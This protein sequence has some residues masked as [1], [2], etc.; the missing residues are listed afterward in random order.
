MFWEFADA[1]FGQHSKKNKSNLLCLF[2]KIMRKRLTF[3][4][5]QG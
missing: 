5:S 3:V 2:G 4:K 1:Q